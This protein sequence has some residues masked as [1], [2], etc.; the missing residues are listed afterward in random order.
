MNARF[1][2]LESRRLLCSAMP[3]IN[4]G[5]DSGWNNGNNNGG[6]DSG[7]STIQETMSSRAVTFAI[8]NVKRVYKFHYENSTTG[9]IADMTLRIRKQDDRDTYAALRSTIDIV[10]NQF[11]T[12]HG[13]GTYGKIRDN[14][15][16]NLTM[17][18]TEPPFTATITGKAS[19]SGSQIKGQLDITG[20]VTMSIPFQFNKFVAS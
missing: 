13:D 15:R 14:L 11:G 5:D 2:G 16:V 9:L 6:D 1:E 10:T 7:T 12:I 3:D 4:G 19:T 18:G 20:A 8:P 17:V